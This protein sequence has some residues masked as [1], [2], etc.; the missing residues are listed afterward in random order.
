MRSSVS[1]V[2]SDVSSHHSTAV[3][4][5]SSSP[6]HKRTAA[7][8]PT[9]APHASSS[10]LDVGSQ[11]CIPTKTI[12]VQKLKLQ[13]LLLSTARPPVRSPHA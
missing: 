12:R 10:V 4:S 5:S 3:L 6:P 7:P 9:E 13:G 2:S 1:P 8:E 11:E